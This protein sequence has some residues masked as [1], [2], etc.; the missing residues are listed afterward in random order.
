M[1]QNEIIFNFQEL[2]NLGVIFSEVPADILNEIHAEVTDMIETKFKTAI[3][4]RKNLLGHLEHEYELK[5]CVPSLEEF[6]LYLTNQYDNRWKYINTRDEIYHMTGTSSL[7]LV[8][9]WIN[10][11]QKHE[12]NPPHVHTGIFSFALWL[13]IP[14]DLKEEENVFPAMTG[15]PRT[16]KFSFHYNNVLGQLQ[17]YALDVDTTYEG[18]LILFPSSLSHSVSPFF[19]TNEYR[20]SISGNLRMIGK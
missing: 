20:I 13:K 3:D 12:F 10:F 15:T 16:S 18:K 9:T 6:L 8:D 19:T 17:H 5:K 14:Y 7:R 1:A 4:Y 2:P 11:Q